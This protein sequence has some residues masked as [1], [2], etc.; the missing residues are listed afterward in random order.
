MNNIN[1]HK[2][3]RHLVLLSVQLQK[4]YRLIKVL[5]IYYQ[6]IEGKIELKFDCL[7]TSRIQLTYPTTRSY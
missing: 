2:Y 3:P 7:L 1:Y 4:Y 6:I 5:F